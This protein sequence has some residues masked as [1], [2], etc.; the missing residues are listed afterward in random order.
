MG[1]VQTDLKSL[2]HVATCHATGLYGCTTQLIVYQSCATILLDF[3]ECI[4][5]S[6]KIDPVPISAGSPF[7]I[8]LSAVVVV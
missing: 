1:R 5:A 2:I 4:F 7:I 3:S 8:G 6:H